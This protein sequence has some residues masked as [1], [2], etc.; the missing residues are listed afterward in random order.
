[1]VE[2]LIWTHNPNYIILELSEPFMKDD[3][4]DGI[5]NRALVFVDIYLGLQF[6]PPK[7]YKGSYLEKLSAKHPNKVLISW[8]EDKLNNV[9]KEEPVNLPENPVTQKIKESEKFVLPDPEATLKKELIEIHADKNSEESKLIR[10]TLEVHYKLI[11]DQHEIIKK[12]HQ[13]IEDL[14]VKHI[15]MMKISNNHAVTSSENL[16]EAYGELMLKTQRIDTERRVVGLY[17]FTD[18]TTTILGRFDPS[19]NNFYADENLNLLAAT[20]NMKYPHFSEIRIKAPS[21][22]NKEQW[23]DVFHA[24]ADK[25]MEGQQNEIDICGLSR[26]GKRMY[27][28]DGRTSNFNNLY[29]INLKN[30][31]K[32][33]AAKEDS[34]IKCFF[35]NIFDAEGEGPDY[36]AYAIGKEPFLKEIDPRLVTF[37]AGL[38]KCLMSDLAEVDQNELEVALKEYFKSGQIF[39]ENP[40]RFKTNLATA[41]MMMY[42]TPS[43]SLDRQYFAI[44]TMDNQLSMLTKA[45]KKTSTIS[46]YPDSKIGKP[47]PI[48]AYATQSGAFKSEDGYSIS[49]YLT[50]PKTDN[51]PFPCVVN[52]HG[53]PWGHDKLEYDLAEHVLAEFLGVATLKVNFRG[54]TGFGKKFMYAGDG[55]WGGKILEDILFVTNKL[56]EKKSIDG[57]KLMIAGGSFGGYVTHAM[58]AFHP[59]VF[60]A[61]YSINGLSDLGEAI[62]AQKTSEIQQYW[63]NRIGG[64]P[65]NITQKR[66]LQTQSPAYRSGRVQEP[67]LCVAGE[68]DE[69]VLPIQTEIMADKLKNS[70]KLVTHVV[71]KNEGHNFEKSENIISNMVLYHGFVAQT[72]NIPFPEKAKDTINKTTDIVFKHGKENLNFM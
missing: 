28:I 67:L 72:F 65:E 26:D 18:E 17:D 35:E 34:D 43:I 60:K 13:E 22:F 58:L 25:Q 57:N 38:A 66:L 71:F 51:G 61:G 54:S 44:P 70:K 7:N 50:K 4:E 52:A 8:V 33:L 1:V 23:V 36:L 5:L 10:K 53:G 49:Y 42:Q 11:R 32:E 14:T 24:R 63:V 9:K 56:V 2:K 48:E 30:G 46:I 27:I 55:Q 68:K 19:I 15:E 40:E 20:S 59:G 41:F 6:S 47:I 37:I 29:T 12:Q 39:Q 3:K 16:I 62:Q 64:D 69:T 31:K 21:K 45:G